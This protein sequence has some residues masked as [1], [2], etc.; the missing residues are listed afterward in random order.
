MHEALAARLFRRTARGL[1][2]ACW[3]LAAT[4]AQ[5]DPAAWRLDAPTGAKLRLLGSMHYLRAGDHPLPPLIDELYADADTLIMELDLDDLDP[6]ATQTQFLQAAMLPIGTTLADVVEPALF[7]R[8]ERQSQ[9]LG[10]DLALLR[11]FE[12]WL[13][14]LTIMDL[15]MGRLGFEAARGLEQH[16]LRQAAADGKEI[17]GLETL[18]TQI[19][20]FDTLSAGEQQ[21]MLDQTLREISE[22][23]LSMDALVDAWR[24][25]ELETL[26]DELLDDFDE[27]PNLYQSL[28]VARNN[29]WIDVLERLLEEPG[30]YLVVVGALHLVGDGSVID[31]LERR[32]HRVERIR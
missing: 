4:L 25:G 9:S 32:G 3:T 1:L 2:L 24:A 21:A 18:T 16:L 7:E 11:Q 30:N 15:G 27:F 28:V 14:A 6:I 23:T 5:A 10:V 20:V 13:I 12:P 26:S 17:I 19:D 22:P 8:A 31:L 29:A